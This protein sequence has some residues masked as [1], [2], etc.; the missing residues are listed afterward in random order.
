MPVQT[1]SPTA[2]QQAAL[3]DR[4][5]HCF[6]PS[7]SP[8]NGARA[9]RTWRRPGCDA[10]RP[11]LDNQELLDAMEWQ[12]LRRGAAMNE[13]DA[14]TLAELKIRAWTW[15]EANRAR[16]WTLPA[17]ADELIP[18]RRIGGY[19][20]FLATLLAAHRSG[21][22]GVW[23]GY[24]ETMAL[25]Q[26]GSTATWRKWTLEMEALGLIRIIRTWRQPPE[27]V[28]ELEGRPKC[29]GKLLYRLGPAWEAYAGPGVLEGAPELS[30]AFERWS[31]QAA[32]G[33]RKRAQQARD[34]RREAFGPDP[35][36]DF[37]AFLDRIVDDHRQKPAKGVDAPAPSESEPEPEAEPEREETREAAAALELEASAPE[38][39]EVGN[40][41]HN[42]V[43]TPIHDSSLREINC[44]NHSPPPPSGG[45]IGSRP[46][47]GHEAR[48]LRSPKGRPA[49]LRPATPTTGKPLPA[50]AGARAL[51]PGRV[52]AG[53]KPG[54]AKAPA[55]ASQQDRV[56]YGNGPASAERVDRVAPERVQAE[57]S[58]LLA[59]LAAK[60]LPCQRGPSKLER[61]STEDP[62]SPTLR[63][64]DP[65]LRVVVG[66]N[67]DAAP[68]KPLDDL[69][70]SSSSKPP[71]PAPI[72]VSLACVAC[73]GS[74]HAGMWTCGNCHGSGRVRRRVHAKCS[75]C[76]GG[77]LE[78]GPALR[79]CSSCGGSG[80][81]SC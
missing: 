49:A 23:L 2:R 27:G 32:G 79:S 58:S 57:V 60:G 53:T 21:A 45:V 34:D 15:T 51:L 12:H 43:I 4:N 16:L 7:S 10:I 30:A 28:A 44:E 80:H 33:A 37:D 11:E 68:L 40:E 25:A 67:G 81:A 19:S 20:R 54:P 78:P 48:A 38:P 50:S 74:G 72:T 59:R 6:G 70:S 26:I 47:A 71:D 46:A 9:D 18:R 35:H 52:A 8:R 65:D 29:Y 22:V 66:H 14:A 77:G 3:E 76:G 5:P 39:R 41:S 75:S 63:G 13:K 1:I 69:A 24:H 64:P 61:R 73:H 31:R 17:W 36:A 56:A 55:R 42:A 62:G